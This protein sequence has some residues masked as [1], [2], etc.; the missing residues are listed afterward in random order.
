MKTKLIFFLLIATHKIALAQLSG[1]IIDK[2]TKQSIPYVN[3]FIENENYGTTADE[4]GKFTI[5]S[6]KENYKLIFSIVGYENDTISI[7]NIRAI[8]ELKP[9]VYNLAEVKVLSSKKSKEIKIGSFKR[10]NIKTYYGSGLNFTYLIASHFPFIDEYN[11]TPFI[12]TIM[13]LCKSDIPNAK[14][15]VRIFEADKN[16]QPSTELIRESIIVTIKKGQSQPLIDLSKYNIYFPEN[17]LFIG[18]EYMNIPSNYYEFYATMPNKKKMKM[19]TYEPSFASERIDSNKQQIWKTYNG[20]W[21][22]GTLDPKISRPYNEKLKLELTL[23][24]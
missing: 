23:T 17:G 11:N 5:Q 15:K 2:N 8:I 13:P 12:K 22:I 21:K 6:Q 7:Q 9:K 18:F 19:F 16:G 20:K 4:N 1:K 24:N 14:F 10:N 3:V